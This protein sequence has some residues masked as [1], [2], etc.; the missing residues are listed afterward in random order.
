M[1]FSLLALTWAAFILI[2]STVGVGVNLPNTWADIIG[3]DK[4]AHAFVYC[5]LT[6]LLFYGWRGKK[7]DIKIIW[8][9]FGIA[10]S[11][12]IL[13]EIVQYSFFPNR[14]FEVLDI[15]A[16]IVGAMLGVFWVYQNANK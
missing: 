15:I 1:R 11:Y 6:V 14:Y 7:P 3:W 2:L 8:M 12:G 10:T 4:V 13:M 9:A 16:N 5:I